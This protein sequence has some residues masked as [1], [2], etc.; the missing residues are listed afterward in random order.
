MTNATSEQLL[1]LFFSIFLMLLQKE[2]V[3]ISDL[4]RIFNRK[5]SS[6][7]F[8]KRKLA[9]RSFLIV[10]ARKSVSLRCFRHL[11]LNYRE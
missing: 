8:F 11:P 1:N 7:D 4:I 6:R 9:P 3:K 10:L 5:L 2:I